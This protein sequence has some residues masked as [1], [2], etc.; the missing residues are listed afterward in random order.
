VWDLSAQEVDPIQ[1][2][3]ESHD[4]AEAV[5]YDDSILDAVRKSPTREKMTPINLPPAYYKAAGE[6]ARKR[7]L[8]AAIRLGALLRLQTLRMPPTCLI[9][10]SEG[11]TRLNRICRLYPFTKLREDMSIRLVPC[12][13]CAGMGLLT[14]LEVIKCTACHGSGNILNAIC[15]SCGGTGRQNIE[16]AAV[17]D[18]CKGVGNVPLDVA[19]TSG[20]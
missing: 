8:A 1:W 13:K 7:V 20:A 2:A 3:T 16:S 12:P 6:Q 4:L 14:A 17:C 9:A 19:P 5:V 15:L 11:S 18:D 10:H